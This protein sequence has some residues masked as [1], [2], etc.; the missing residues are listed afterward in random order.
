MSLSRIRIGRDE[1]FLKRL[2]TAYNRGGAEKQDA[3]NTINHFSTAGRH[4][5]LAKLI[6]LSSSYHF[7]APLCGY[8]SQSISTKASVSIAVPNDIAT[9]L[10]KIRDD[11][12]TAVLQFDRLRHKYEEIGN[13]LDATEK[14]EPIWRTAFAALAGDIDSLTSNLLQ[15]V[16]TEKL[17]EEPPISLRGAKA[18]FEDEAIAASALEADDLLLFTDYAVQLTGLSDK[19]RVIVQNWNSV[20]P[21]IGAVGHA[22]RA[23]KQR[24]RR[25][26]QS[27]LMQWAEVPMIKNE[28][29]IIKMLERYIDSQERTLKEQLDRLSAGLGNLAGAARS[30]AGFIKAPA[31]VSP[32]Q[33]VFIGRSEP[34]SPPASKTTPIPFS[35]PVLLGND[36]TMPIDFQEN[37]IRKDRFLVIKRLGS[38]NMAVAFLVFDRSSRTEIVL[39]F[40][41]MEQAC[42][43]M[44]LERFSRGEAKAHRAAGL[45]G[46]VQYYGYD[47]VDRHEYLRTIDWTEAAPLGLPA[48]VP[49]IAMEYVDGPTLQE[50][51]N[52]RRLSTRETLVV[53]LDL[54]KILQRLHQNRIIHRDL[55]PDNIFVTKK[56]VKISD[57]GIAKLLT[58][59]PFNR[60]SLTPPNLILGTPEYMSPEALTSVVGI[61]WKS[62]QYAFGAI[63]Y[64]MLSG[65]PP[66][67]GC[68]ATPVELWVYA[69]HINNDEVPDLRKTT[70]IPDKLWDLIKR[71]LAKKPD[72]RY[73][74]W[75]EL[76]VELEEMKINEPGF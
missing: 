18:P 6:D 76:I 71:T 20:K 75:P 73:R 68:G 52:Q 67:G 24:H 14:Q 44:I 23:T 36:G 26:E 43:P 51:I 28:I 42:N 58:S 7:A 74:T 40:P 66:F 65:H 13:R 33:V 69:N 10:E 54:A 25:F 2:V 53:A 50:I 35:V 8:L 12:A 21:K 38:G 60:P 29:E 45:P 1:S 56:G 30:L 9:Q 62:D 5:V 15:A 46:I 63:V 22:I 31:L 11:V 27:E 49:F 57:F 34:V 72:E 41:L 32:Q 64:E 48:F 61:D 17:L 3:L 4:T 55:K 39:K 47:T 70:T 16:R 37:L 19:L 59:P